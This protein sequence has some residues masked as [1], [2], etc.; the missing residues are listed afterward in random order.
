MNVGEYKS[1]SVGMDV[2]RSEDEGGCAGESEEQVSVRMWVLL[3][4]MPT[5]ERSR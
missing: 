1:E 2:R 3:T 5:S 4:A